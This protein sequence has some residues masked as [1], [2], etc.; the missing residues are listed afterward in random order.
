MAEVGAFQLFIVR[1]VLWIQ[2]YI[3]AGQ[4]YSPVKPALTRRRYSHLCATRET[5]TMNNAEVRN[6][7]I[8]GARGGTCFML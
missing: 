2:P 5:A 3:L 1:T 7:N 6:G 8:S 4:W